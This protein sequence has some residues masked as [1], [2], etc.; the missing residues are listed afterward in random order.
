MFYKR[1]CEISK[2]KLLRCDIKN[3]DGT[4]FIYVIDNRDEKFWN[5]ITE[6]FIDITDENLYGYEHWS[7]D[8]KQNNEKLT[9]YVEEQKTKIDFLHKISGENK[10]FCQ[11]YIL[12]KDPVVFLS[13]YFDNDLNKFIQFKNNL[14]YRFCDKLY[15]QLKDINSV[16]IKNVLICIEQIKLHNFSNFKTFQE[17][18]DYWP[19]LLRPNPFLL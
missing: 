15:E 3:R 8:I 7:N 16:E 17:T 11:K 2:T 4:I 18:H 10:D 13:N 12:C 5:L 9:V 19:E 14:I 6:S 1:F